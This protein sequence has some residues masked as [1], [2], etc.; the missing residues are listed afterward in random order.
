M[1]RPSKRAHILASALQVVRDGGPHALTLE[2]V[3]ARGAVSKGGLL[4]HFQVSVQG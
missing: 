1:A 4:Y 3:A 2:A